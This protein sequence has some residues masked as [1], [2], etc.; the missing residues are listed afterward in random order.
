MPAPWIDI[1]LTNLPQRRHLAVGI[2]G[3][4]QV[5]IPLQIEPEL[6]PGPERLAQGQGRVRANIAPA[7]DDL[8]KP[9]IGPAQVLGECLLGYT[10]RLQELLEQH[11][12]GMGRGTFVG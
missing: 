10:E 3:L 6:R 9:G 5:P 4:P 12:A 2:H 7:V 8:V 1:V 11:L